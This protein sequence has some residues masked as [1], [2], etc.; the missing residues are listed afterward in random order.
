MDS[1]QI[2][3]NTVSRLEQHLKERETSEKALRLQL[4]KDRFL[5]RKAEY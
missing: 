4:A 5:H 3:L 2:A 1:D